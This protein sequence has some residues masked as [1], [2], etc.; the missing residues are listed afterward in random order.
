MSQNKPDHKRIAPHMLDRYTQC[1]TCEGDGVVL[2]ECD[3]CNGV[4]GHYECARCSGYG[5][6]YI[7]CD[8]C[9]GTGIVRTR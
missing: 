4:A 1:P 7:D 5:Q 2:V 8:S 6:Y 3:D 9:L